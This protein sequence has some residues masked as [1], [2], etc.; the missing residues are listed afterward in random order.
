MHTSTWIN[1]KNIMVNERNET[2]KTP[3]YMIPFRWGSGKGKNYGCI[4]YIS[5]C[6]VP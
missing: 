1:L 6:L 4:K 5:G 3:Y 2:Q